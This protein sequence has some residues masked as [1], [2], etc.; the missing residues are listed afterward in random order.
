MHPIAATGRP[1]YLLSDGDHEAALQTVA[2]ELLER[3]LTDLGCRSGEVVGSL[4]RGEQDA[5]SDIDLLLHAGDGKRGSEIIDGLSC[6]REVLLAPWREPTGRDQ[7]EESYSLFLRHP[8]LNRVLKI[9]VCVHTDNAVPVSA[10]WSP[11]HSLGEFASL[12]ML[13]AKAL[14][15]TD[16]L[17]AVGAMHG[18]AENLLM[19]VAQSHSQ[20][21]AARNIWGQAWQVMALLDPS[22]KAADVVR[23]IP[24]RRMAIDSSAEFSVVVREH[25]EALAELYR[26]VDTLSKQ[27]LSFAQ[28]IAQDIDRLSGE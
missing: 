11:A 15:R 26:G 2:N 24:D 27:V 10:A 25:S 6:E 7:R 21:I 9:D 12:V 17:K 20:D 8:A 23:S 18:L 1:R 13:A 4:A 14:L 5:V 22:S 19:S 3:C 16:R 28:L